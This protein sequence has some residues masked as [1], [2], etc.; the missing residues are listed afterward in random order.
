MRDAAVGAR[1]KLLQNV[2]E[3]HHPTGSWG[4]SATYVAAPDL[5]SLLQQNITV[6]RQVLSLAIFPDLAKS[7]LFSED[8]ILRARN[9]SRPLNEVHVCESVARFTCSRDDL[10][11]KDTRQACIAENIVLGH[12]THQASL[13]MQLLL[14]SERDCVLVPIPDRTWAPAVILHGGRAEG[15]HLQYESTEAQWRFCVEQMESALSRASSQVR[16]CCCTSG[17]AWLRAE[18]AWLRACSIAYGVA[19]THVR[20]K[21]LQPP[22][23]QDRWLGTA[24]RAHWHTVYHGLGGMQ[25]DGESRA[26]GS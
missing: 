4:G 15:Y 14:R 26:D 18:F 24:A 21:T 1:A 17:F 13:V 11:P 19:H 6:F 8:I 12:G 5:H 25:R 23:M 9:F 20:I 22:I 10:N 3:K 16:L 7:E 2:G